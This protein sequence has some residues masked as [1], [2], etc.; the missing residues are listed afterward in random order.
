MY[1]EGRK[2]GGEG[3]GEER[4]EICQGRKEG[5][6]RMSKG[7]GKLEIN[8]GMKIRGREKGKERWNAIRKDGYQDRNTGR[9]TGKK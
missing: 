8:K 6:I 1:L 4:K 2:R 9:N 3:R 5:T 7:G